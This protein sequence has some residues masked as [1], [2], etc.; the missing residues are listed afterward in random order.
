MK[1]EIKEIVLGLIEKS[2]KNEVNWVHVNETNLAEDGT[3]TIEH[4]YAVSTSHFS[5]NLFTT[6]EDVGDV[7]V[8][9]IRFNIHN[10]RGD[11]VSFTSAKLNEPD[12]E[13]LNKLLEL[14]KKIV[15]GEDKLLNTI[16]NDLL[17]P[18]VLGTEDDDI[19]F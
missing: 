2:E 18:G 6:T 14:A 9:A 13:I 11:L 4:D 12:Y 16:K 19:A 7:K 15:L 1:D 10:N 8:G 5:I 17:K 3:S